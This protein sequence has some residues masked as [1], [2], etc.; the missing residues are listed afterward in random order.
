MLAAAAQDGIEQQRRQR[1]IIDKVG[2]IIIAEIAKILPIGNVCLRDDN[3]GRVQVFDDQ[4]EQ[5]DQ[6]M[7]LRKMHAATTGFLP[8]K[9]DGIQAEVADTLLNVIADDSDD[10]QQHIRIAIVQIH[11]IFTKG[12]PDLLDAINAWYLSQ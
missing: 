4:A 9:G 6:F 1:K 8:K 5:F 10:L 7:R 12:A 11:L 2:F 3:S